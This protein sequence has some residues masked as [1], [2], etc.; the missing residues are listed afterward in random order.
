MLDAHGNEESYAEQQDHW[1]SRCSD[2]DFSHRPRTFDIV[3]RFGARV[4]R[5]KAV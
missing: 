4:A 3:N 2:Y 5:L 1:E